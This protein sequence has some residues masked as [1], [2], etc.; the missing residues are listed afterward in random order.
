LQVVSKD[1]YGLSVGPFSDELAQALLQEKEA[2]Q[3][4]VQALKDLLTRLDNTPAAMNQVP[5]AFASLLIG[6]NHHI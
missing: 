3:Q 4:S 5:P 1:I 2:L 6:L